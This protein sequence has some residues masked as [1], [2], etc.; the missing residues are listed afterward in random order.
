MQRAISLPVLVL[1]LGA[2]WLPSEASCQVRGD[3]KGY[4]TFSDVAYNAGSLFSH[5][6]QIKDSAQ[7]V[8]A[9]K[10]ACHPPSLRAPRPL[11]PE[12]PLWTEEGKYS[13]DHYRV[14]SLSKPLVALGILKLQEQ[15]RLKID[16]PVAKHLGEN[17][18]SNPWEETRPVRIAH[19]LEHSAGLDDMHFNEY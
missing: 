5:V 6:A 14:G 4:A 2:L 10:L 17:T 7:A 8:E 12:Y 19:L 3:I 18:L 1:L 15:G 13:A 9:Q 11:S 16:D